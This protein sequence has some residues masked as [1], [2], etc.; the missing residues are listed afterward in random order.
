MFLAFLGV[1]LS[2]FGGVLPFAR[3]MLVDRTGWM[4]ELDFTE[5]LSLCQSLPG[6]NIVNLSVVVG[7]RYAGA[8]GAFA[9]LA[10]LIVAPVAIVIVLA[11][12]NDRFGAVGRAPDML[13]ALGAAAAGL[14]A[15]TVAKIAR[16]ILAARWSAVPVIA[17]V[18][19]GVALLRLPL[20]LV[21]AIGA[22]LSLAL[23][24]RRPK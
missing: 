1:G 10:G 3:R 24:W 15:A 8:K 16:P 21:L 13:L 11:L 6:P 2:G 4:T 20:P 23:G 9:C 14:V 19:A 5:T 7:S 22:P 12:L 18:F 17:L